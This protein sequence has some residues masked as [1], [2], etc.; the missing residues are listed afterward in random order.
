MSAPGPSQPLAIATA[1]LMTVIWGTT[2]AVI[3][4]SLDGFPPLKGLAIRFAIA[5]A[6]LL[7]VARFAGVRLGRERHEAALW[8]MQSAFAFGFAY[9]LVYWAEQWV[10]SGLAALL[11]STMPFFVALFAFFAIPEERLGI[12]GL[13]GLVVG[14]GGVAVIFSED[15]GQLGGAAVRRAALVVLAAPLCAAL[16]QV[17]V[18][19]WGRKIHALSLTAVP[20]AM[21]ALMLGILAAWWERGRPIVLDPAPVAAVLYLAVVGSAIAFSLYFWLLKYVPVTKLSLI[22]Y[23]IP[24]VA[25]AIGTIFLDEPLTLRM[26]AGGSLVIAGGALV[27]LPRK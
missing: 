24:V 21:S 3:R 18:K 13:C 15:L 12:L 8:L 20:M 25:V 7:P 14:F 6:I 10:P 27:M 2:W 19:R 11:F 5:A 1:V 22:T 23:A 16:A 17:A 26:V 4:V 9:G